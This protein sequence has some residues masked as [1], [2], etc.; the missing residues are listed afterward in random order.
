VR[1]HSSSSAAIPC[2]TSPSRAARCRLPPNRIN[3]VSEHA[4]SVAKEGNATWSRPS[5]SARGPNSAAIRRLR[6]A[7]NHWVLRWVSVK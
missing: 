2:S 6:D 1:S 4:S 3:S 7:A 5:S